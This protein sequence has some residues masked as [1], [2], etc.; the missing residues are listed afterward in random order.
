MIT[1]TTDGV[2]LSGERSLTRAELARRAAR[3]ASGLSALGVGEDDFIAV[4]LRNDFAFFEAFDGASLIGAYVVPVNWHFK[5]EEVG[6]ILSDSGAKAVVIHADLLPDLRSAVP[7]GM[8]VLVVSTPPE[9]AT[10]YPAAS[11]TPPLQPGERDWETWRDTNAPWAHPAREGRSGVFYTSGTT[12]KPKGVVRDPETDESGG[13]IDKLTTLIFGLEDDAPMRSVITGPVYHAMPFTFALVSVH[14]AELVVMQPKFEPEQLLELVE[15]HRIT[16][17]QLVPTMFKRLLALPEDVRTRHDLSSLRF[18]SH[19]AAPCPPD[20]KRAMI[21]WWGPVIY[22]YYGGTETGAVTFHNSHE[23]LAHPGTVGRPIEGCAIRI[24]SADGKA[25]APG[26]VGEIFMGN[27][28]LP[29]FTYNNEDSKRQEVELDGL[30]TIGDVGYLD[31]DGYLYITDRARD[32]V[33]SGGV[34]IYPAEIEAALMGMPQVRDCAV[35][36]IPDDEFGEALCA[37]VSMEPDAPFDAQEIKAW[38]G[39]RLAKY[40]VP[41]TFVHDESLPREDSGKVMKR[42]VRAQ[43]W[44]VDGKA[45]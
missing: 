36:G 23:A 22:E 8:P 44:P 29:D 40:K 10:A 35:F 15:A 5:A 18:V 12:G 30:V 39:E 6:Y 27:P 19:S 3:V 31:A 34:N 24:V 21:E 28:K 1:E 16:H 2:I 9:I 25:C 17:L 33:I 11:G 13:E 26:E 37:H 32:M 7:A 43:Y 20:L 14:V 45:I 38:L 41:R 42:K 4:I